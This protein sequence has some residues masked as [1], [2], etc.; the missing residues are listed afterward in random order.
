MSARRAR[1]SLEHEVLAALWAADAPMTPEQVRTEL[2]GGLAYTTVLTTLVRLLEKGAV[3]RSPHGRGHAYTPVVDDAGMV[4]LRMRK[5]LDSETDRVG[6]LRRF[7]AELDGREAAAVR[8][9]LGRP[10]P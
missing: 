1:G 3:Q 7:V 5:L 2:G 6:V 4:A 8:R 9:A 10:A